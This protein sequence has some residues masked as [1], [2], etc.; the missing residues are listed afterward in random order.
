M[1][2]IL[3]V[4]DVFP[5]I[6]NRTTIFFRNI[7]PILSQ[8][9]EI[10][11]FWL[12]TDDYGKR[13]Q[14]T[15]PNYEILFMSNFTNAVE[16]L[17]KI[18]PDIV[19]HLIGWNVV[20]YAFIVARKFLKIP[21]FGYTDYGE[22]QYFSQSIPWIWKRIYEYFKKFFESSDGGKHNIRKIRG[23]NFLKKILFL[24]KTIRASGRTYITSIIEMIDFFNFLRSKSTIG[25]Y[26]KYNCDI[27]FAELQGQDANGLVKWGL[28]KE[29]IV[30]IGNP[31]FDDAF[32]KRELPIHHSNDK[33]N[34]LFLTVNLSVMQGKSNW[35]KTRRDLMIKELIRNLI[36]KRK[37]IALTIKIHP[38]SE[39]YTEYKKLLEPYKEVRLSQIDEVTE[40]LAKTDVVITSCTSTAGIIALVMKKPIIIWNYFQVEGDMLLREGIALECKN[41]T[42]LYDCLKNAKV[43]RDSKDEKINRFIKEHV[44]E[45]KAVQKIVYEL[46]QWL[47][48]NKIV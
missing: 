42:K 4:N 14:V 22:I 20:H 6:N 5:N 1:L 45:E 23:T 21:S 46:E 13:P 33:L 26:S 31:V 37:E 27:M 41:S 29:N 25:R 7:M 3:V 18:K 40:L 9:F 48:N 32:K 43:F 38:T 19:Y 28:K 44:G 36:N 35:S 17:E 15:N 2:K 8:K 47:K 30:L 39:I 16:V 34:V 11:I 12:I 24:F 10:K